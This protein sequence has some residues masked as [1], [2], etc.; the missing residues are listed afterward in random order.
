MANAV[1]AAVKGPAAVAG[2][3]SSALDKMKGAATTG[4]FGTMEHMRSMATAG[5]G[6]NANASTLSQMARTGMAEQGGAGNSGS[7]GSAGT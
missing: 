7:D 5:V 4:G 3:A 2:A 1:A 6:D